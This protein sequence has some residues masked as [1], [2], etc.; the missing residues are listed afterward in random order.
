MGADAIVIGAGT[1]GAAIAFGLANRGLKVTLLDGSDADH[2]AAVSNFG[3]IWLQGKGMRMPAYQRLSRS[4]V[5]QWPTFAARLSSFLDTPLDYQHDGGLTFC[6]GEAAFEKR[7]SDLQH[8]Q[9]VS[10]GEADWEMLDRSA[11]Q[12]LVPRVTF[13]ADVAGASLGRLDGHVNPL[14]LLA[15]LMTAIR[16]M[17]G[18]VVQGA[19]VHGVCAERGSF[20]VRSGD[21]AFHADRLVIAAGLGSEALARHLGIEVSLRPQRGQIQVT[22]RVEPFLPLPTIDIRQTA[23]GTM[24]GTT[25]EDAGFDRGS[26]AEAAARLSERALR[27]MPGLKDVRLIRQWAGLRVMTPDTYPI[28]AQSS[29]FPGAFVALCHSGVTLAPLHATVVADA[30]FESRLPASL[31]PFHCDRFNVPHAA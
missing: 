24:I 22:E 19:P 9:G 1:V 23:E 16:C 20:T 29:A 7:R 14:K 12:K 8:L 25:H 17:G 26:T 27:V 4:S 15:G 21:K 5:T 3:L 10:G 31:A 13:G 30:V 11:L 18:A 6:L 28:Y 2:R